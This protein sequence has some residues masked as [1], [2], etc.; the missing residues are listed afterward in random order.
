[1]L[2]RRCARKPTTCGEGLVQESCMLYSPMDSLWT[3]HRNVLLLLV[4]SFCS[5][6]EK[7][8]DWSL[9][10]SIL[11][12]YSVPWCVR[13]NLFYNCTY[14][15]FYTMNASLPDQARCCTLTSHVFHASLAWV[16]DFDLVVLRLLLEGEA[17][18]EVPVLQY[19]VET[20]EL[21]GLPVL[22]NSFC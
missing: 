15:I 10:W 13:L 1:M 6:W 5:P 3:R 11:R 21:V 12:R 4:S 19:V 2:S 18:G 14:F 9:N 20:M 22:W 7:L 17:L 8:R 16:I